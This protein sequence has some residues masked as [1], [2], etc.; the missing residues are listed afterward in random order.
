MNTDQF[1]NELEKLKPSSTFLTIHGY[2]NEHSEVADYSIAF[3]MSYKSALE[4]SIEKLQTLTLTKEL[5]KQAREELVASFQKSLLNMEA[6]PMEERDD[7][8]TH[9]IGNDDKIIKGVKLHLATGVLH[10]YGLVVFKKILLPGFYQKVNHRP[11]T[12]AK[13]K[14]RHLT[15]AGKFRQFKITPGQVDRIVVQGLSL[16][17]PEE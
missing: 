1:L 2:R 6:I 11:L 3:H 7:A 15:P 10:L 5:E 8:Y 14:L 17:P 9:F 13:D 16:L 4:R 12:I